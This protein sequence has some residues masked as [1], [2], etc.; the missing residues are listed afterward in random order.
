MVGLAMNRGDIDG[1]GTGI[2]R[3]LREVRREKQEIVHAF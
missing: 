1:Y 3:N 2:E